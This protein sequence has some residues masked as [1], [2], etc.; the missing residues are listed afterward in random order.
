MQTS[1]LPKITAVDTKS[2]PP[3]PPCWRHGALWGF[4]WLCWLTAIAVN[5]LVTPGANWLRHNDKPINW[6]TVGGG[7]E[8][9]FGGC[10]VGLLNS[11]WC[12]YCE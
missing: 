7:D 4:V 9:V 6:F 5:V 11:H 1:P 12:S 10:D 3:S 8:E 2:S